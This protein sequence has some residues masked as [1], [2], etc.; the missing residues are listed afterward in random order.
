MTRETAWIVA[1]YL[2]NNDLLTNNRIYSIISNLLIITSKAGEIPKGNT[3]SAQRGRPNYDQP[4][5][6]PLQ[7]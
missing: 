6:A 3:N 1:S 7:G 2:V 4:Q 5:L